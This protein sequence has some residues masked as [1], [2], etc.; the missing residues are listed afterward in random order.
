MFVLHG[1]GVPAM[2]AYL[3]GET[4]FMERRPLKQ[5]LTKRFDAVRTTHD[6]FL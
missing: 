2:N 5:E 4:Y 3:G 6:S 1:E